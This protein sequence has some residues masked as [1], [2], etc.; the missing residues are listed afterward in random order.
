MVSN[1]IQI[2]FIFKENIF[3][4]LTDMEHQDLQENCIFA[5]ILAFYQM[6]NELVDRESTK[7]A[8]ITSA[9]FLKFQFAICLCYMAYTWEDQY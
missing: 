4:L 2:Y 5:V 3:D 1:T 6:W 7:F 9:G 8:G